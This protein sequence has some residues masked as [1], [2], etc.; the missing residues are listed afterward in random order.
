ME[1]AIGIGWAVN[2][3][4]STVAV[5]CAVGSRVDLKLARNGLGWYELSNCRGGEMVNAAD[6]KS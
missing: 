6:L 2:V 1:D 5:V 3:K 4:S